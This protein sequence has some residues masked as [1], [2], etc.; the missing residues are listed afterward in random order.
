MKVIFISSIIFLFSCKQTP[1]QKIDK[2]LSQ[3]LEPTEKK[4]NKMKVGETIVFGH[5][6]TMGIDRGHYPA[7]SYSNEMDTAFFKFVKSESFND[8]AAGGSAYYYDIYKAVKAGT[9]K[10]EYNKT[11]QNYLEGPDSVNS[12]IEPFTKEKLAT[13]NFIITE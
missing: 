12:K 13:Y 9:T 4:D 11:T 10:I 1:Q 3:H 5:G 8:G 6:E 2:L 7:P